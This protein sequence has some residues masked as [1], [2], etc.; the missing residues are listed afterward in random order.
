MHC[1]LKKG[2][3]ILLYFR[4]FPLCTSNPWSILWT[5]SIG[6]YNFNAFDE[7]KTAIRD[8]IHVYNTERPHQSLNYLSPDQFRAQK[9]QLVA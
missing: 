5:N 9:L 4:I 1:P 8:W 3:Q 2:S 7:A 6:L